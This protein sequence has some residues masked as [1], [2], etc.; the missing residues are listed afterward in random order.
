MNHTVEEGISV[1]MDRLSSEIKGLSLSDTRD[2]RIHGIVD[3]LGP[4]LVREPY[5]SPDF[6]L[7]SPIGE[8]ERG[9]LVSY[10]LALPGEEGHRLFRVSASL[11]QISSDAAS[12]RALE[13]MYVGPNRNG[14]IEAD[15]HLL[16]ARLFI[17]NIH[18][19][20]AVRNR[21][22]VVKSEFGR[23]MGVRLAEG[24]QETKVLSVAAGSSRA[25]MEE[26]A[27]LN[28]RGYDRIKL[29]MVDINR[30]ALLDGRKLVA[31]LG[32]SE[33]VEFIRAHILIFKRYLE[34]GYKPDFVEIVGLLDYLDE[35]QIT[36]LLVQVRNHLSKGGEV[37]FSNIAPNDE[38]EF[39]H[40]IV[41]WPKMQYRDSQ[42]LLRVAT[43]AGFTPDKLRIISE[44]LGIYNIVSARK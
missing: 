40:R 20:M 16:W 26:L 39:T 29:R 22:R 19:S 6:E 36:K 28:G 33:S 12:H 34:D 25:I 18:N 13:T 44:P 4:K 2:M 10:M 7:A 38:E 42:D 9:Q 37:L 41:G 27:V 32:I 11:D 17:E 5:G 3:L 15:D 1:G 23:F 14:I 31:K 43:A 8:S 35:E 24:F 30:E 21:L